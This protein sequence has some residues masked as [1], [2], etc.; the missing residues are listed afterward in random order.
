MRLLA[1]AHS[2]CCVC[3]HVCHSSSP[4]SLLARF[5]TRRHAKNQCIGRYER[6]ACHVC[7]A[8]TLAGKDTM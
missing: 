2:N 6:V 5:R 4:C 7:G 8:D 1:F 3:K